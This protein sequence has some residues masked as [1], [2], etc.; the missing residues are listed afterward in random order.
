MHYEWCSYK[1]TAPT[2]PER[3]IRAER[4][5]TEDRPWSGIRTESLTPTLSASSIY[6]KEASDKKRRRVW[7]TSPALYD[8]ALSLIYRAFRDIDV[9]KTAGKPVA[10][11]PQPIKIPAKH[12]LERIMSR[13]SQWHTPCDKCP[14]WHKPLLYL[15]SHSQDQTVAM[16]Y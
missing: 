5:T 12:L 10:K 1:H 3:V 7:C 2:K 9:G 11:K 15:H 6:I 4:Q 14:F 16:L 8:P 13:L